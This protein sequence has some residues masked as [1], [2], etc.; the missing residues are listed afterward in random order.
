[1]LNGRLNCV[2]KTSSGS[3]IEPIWLSI[4]S[5]LVATRISATSLGTELL[6]GGLL[7]GI[8]V[9]VS[10]SV[11]CYIDP[12]FAGPRRPRGVAERESQSNS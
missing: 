12:G 2:P 3:S 11:S 6:A 5:L 7:A 10:Q 9:F 8:P 4:G 1:M